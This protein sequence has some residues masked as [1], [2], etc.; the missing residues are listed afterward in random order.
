M[1]L[2]PDNVGLEERQDIKTLVSFQEVL[3]QEPQQ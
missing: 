2:E 3:S 1:L